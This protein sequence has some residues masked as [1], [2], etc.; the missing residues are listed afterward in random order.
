M[1]AIHIAHPHEG[2]DMIFLKVEINET[3]AIDIISKRH[4]MIHQF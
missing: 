3:F 1:I 2:V 4:E